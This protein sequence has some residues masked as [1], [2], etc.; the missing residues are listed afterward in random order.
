MTINV[1][2]N[3]LGTMGRY[4]L[5]AIQKE[6][7][8]GKLQPGEIEV[9]AFNDLFPAKQL[10]PLLAHDSIYLGFPGIGGKEGKVEADG[11]DLIVNGKR[12][13]GFA[14]REPSKIPFGDLGANVVYESSGAFTDLPKLPT[15][16]EVTKNNITPNQLE[17]IKEKR[18]KLEETIS[19]YFGSVKPGKIIY[20]APTKFA[21]V[22]IVVGVNNKMYVG[23]YII[24]NASCTTNCLAPLSQALLDK[25]GVYKGLMTT[26]HAYTA[27]QRLVDAAHKDVARSYAATL[28][29]IPTST[30]AAIAIGEVIKEL[31]GKLNGIAIRGPV[32]VGS[33]VDLVA[34]FSKEV[35]PE[36]V[37]KVVKEAAEGYLKGALEYRKG[38]IVSSMVLGNPTP[39]VF[40]AKETMTVGNLAKVISYYDNVAG[41]THQ[42]LK[43]TRLVAT[44]KPSQ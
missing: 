32:P 20:S 17:E 29:F 10:A 11:N 12:I 16:E 37:S 43:L 40:D 19:K 42:A 18:Q 34:E 41:Y 33:L 9:V 28:N 24:S 5:R 8:E 25:F 13:R 21:E 6:I 7:N 30:G 23:Q 1:V 4:Y 26:I 39:S 22:T 44:Y 2:V 15:P 35:S 3:G 36:E 27:D 14:E 31:K 38:P